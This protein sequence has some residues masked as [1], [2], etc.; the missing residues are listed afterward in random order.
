MTERTKGMLAMALSTAWG[1]LMLFEFLHQIPQERVPLTFKSGPAKVLAGQ[2]SQETD[3]AFIVRPARAKLLALPHLP[4]R[5]IFAPID[6]PGRD[7]GSQQATRQ[8]GSM[9]AKRIPP[10]KDAPTASPPP[11][12]APQPSVEELAAQQAARDAE[13]ARLESKRDLETFRYVGFLERNGVAQA[14]LARGN[15][16]YVVANGDAVDSRYVVTA[17]DTRSVKIRATQT[18]VEATI[19]KSDR[20]ATP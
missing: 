4:S 9:H 8:T 13:I 14:F 11:P 16:L 5:N 1:G 17:M 12:P 7:G 20:E 2:S 18:G 19:G 10:P 3:A 15:E 6:S